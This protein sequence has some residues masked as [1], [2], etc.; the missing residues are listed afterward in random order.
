[1]QHS[2]LVTVRPQTCSP[3]PT[4]AHKSQVRNHQSSPL[5]GGYRP[6]AEVAEYTVSHSH[7]IENAGPDHAD[8][9]SRTLH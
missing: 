7:T 1:M 9:S 5:S 4:N 2:T 6:I 8:I 3:S